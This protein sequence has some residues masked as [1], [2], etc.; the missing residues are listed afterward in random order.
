MHGRLDPDTLQDV[1]NLL[2]ESNDEVQT[3]WVAERMPVSKTAQED[4]ALE[5]IQLWRM[6]EDR[7]RT[8]GLLS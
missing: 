3:V 6:T 1:L 5:R 4:G 7:A 8:I 2:N